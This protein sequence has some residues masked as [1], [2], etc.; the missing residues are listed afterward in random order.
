VRTGV[1]KRPLGAARVPLPGVFFGLLGLGALAGCAGYVALVLS[2]ATWAEARALDAIF[3]YDGWHIQPFSAGAYRQATWAL[4]GAALGL[5]A[6]WLGLART[7]VGRAELVATA[8]EVGAARRRLGAQWRA[9]PGRQ[10]GLALGGLVALTLVRGYLSTGYQPYGDDAI[11]YEFFVRHRLLAVAAYYPMPNNHILANTL[12]WGCY[13]LWPSFWASMRL[14]VL[15]TSTLG[16]GLLFGVLLRRVGFGA[17]LLATGAF[18]WLQLGLYYASNGRGYWLVLLLAGV[19]FWSLLHLLDAAADAPPAGR[20]AWL[21]VLVAGILGCYTVPTFAYVLAS[22]FSWLALRA[23]R[24]R[25]WRQLGHAVAVGMLVGVGAAVLYAPVLLV[26]GA[27][28]LVDNDFMQPRSVLDFWRWLP[29]YAWLTE[30][31][32]AGQRT[33]GAGLTLVV[34]GL[35]G[36]LWYRAATGRLPAAQARRVLG[37]GLPAL[38]FVGLPYAVLA[39]QRVQAPERTLLYKAWFFF[40][41][42]ALILADRRWTPARRWLA[43][44]AA[45]VFVLYEAGTAV[46]LSYLGRQ[47]GPGERALYAWLVHHPQPQP[48]LVPDYG[49]W[50]KLRLHAHVQAPTQP[51][52]AAYQARPGRRY[53]YLVT[54][55]P[56]PPA[57]GRLVYAVPGYLIYQ[58]GPAAGAR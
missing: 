37:V 24:R 44:L 19:V 54:D 49:L 1:A 8:H 3:P 42:L 12:S 34:L 38:W 18:S 7:R 10:R 21:G 5:A 35:F 46:R 22:A 43:G 33:L 23:A 27:K 39:V 58:L 20:A 31:F 28:V 2:T 13:Q 9:L 51:W 36:Q 32:L 57:A 14:P 29:E 15:L 11:S 52:R 53:G 26:S 6:G 4:A 17:A 47:Q 30:G 50:L 45:G 56:A 41:L 55:Q 40:L 25:A 48:T 16:S